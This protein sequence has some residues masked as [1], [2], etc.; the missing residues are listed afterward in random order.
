M[1]DNTDTIDSAPANL[2]FK[3]WKKFGFHKKGGKLDKGQAIC[4]VCR[5]RIKHNKSLHSHGETT[6]RNKCWQE[7]VCG[8]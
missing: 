6:W 1:A 4:M 8:C 7:G 3:V 2:K 5:T